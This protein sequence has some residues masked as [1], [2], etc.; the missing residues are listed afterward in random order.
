[1]KTRLVKRFEATVEEALKQAEGARQ[2]K[3]WAEVV[4]WLGAARGSAEWLA[5]REQLRTGRVRPF[6]SGMQYLDWQ[7]ANCCRCQKCTGDDGACEINDTISL[8]A[9]GD[10]TVSAEIAKRMGYASPL[11]YCW[12]CPEREDVNG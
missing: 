4:T 9:C 1:M 3:R 10:G 11:A 2:V 7:D 6:S 8:A 12:E 5:K